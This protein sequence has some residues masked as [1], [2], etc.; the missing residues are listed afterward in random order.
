LADEN[1]L[2]L[3]VTEKLM[4]YCAGLV[5]AG[6]G[7]GPQAIQALLVVAMIQLQRRECSAAEVADALT[8]AIE[9]ATKI[10]STRPFEE[11][12]IVKYRSRS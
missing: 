5:A 4:Q 1:K 9:A 3:R 11:G 7:T 6:E 10:T 8:D 12:R 2:N